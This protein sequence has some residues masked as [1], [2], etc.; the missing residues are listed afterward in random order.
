MSVN[1]ISD[2]NSLYSHVVELEID[3]PATLRTETITFSYPRMPVWVSNSDDTTGQN[4]TN[5]LDK[6]TGLMSLIKGVSESYK[7]YEVYGVV[8]FNLKNK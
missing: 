2:V 5:N 1:E 4:V 6:T 8:T 7:N 3:N